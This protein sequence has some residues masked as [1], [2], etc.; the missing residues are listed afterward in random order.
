[1]YHSSY[2]IL[3]DDRFVLIVEGEE[4]KGPPE[5]FVVVV[6]WSEGLPSAEE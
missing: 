2:D 5:K 6:N 1:M 4:Q 3:P